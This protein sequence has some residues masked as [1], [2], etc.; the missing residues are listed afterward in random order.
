M[1]I[2]FNVKYRPQIES[3][4]YKVETRDG[5]PAKIIYW[6][7]KGYDDDIKLVVIIGE[8]GSQGVITMS[9]SGSFYSDY[10]VGEEHRYDLFIVTPEPKLTEFETAL[11]DLL[12]HC[13]GEGMSGKDMEKLARENSSRLLDLAKKE[14]CIGYTKYLQGH[15]DGV[16]SSE[17]EYQTGY[18]DGHSAAEKEIYTQLNKQ[19]DKIR[20][21]Q[22]LTL[23]D[24][25]INVQMPSPWI[26]ATNPPDNDRLVFICVNDNGVPQC[27]GCGYYRHRVW[28]DAEGKLDYPDYWMEIPELPKEE[29]K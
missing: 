27:V 26:P 17:K 8:D 5:E 23:N 9:K 10:L 1:K 12:Y 22:Q 24:I 7:L 11:K 20:N 25:G 3:G 2:D 15:I 21:L 19:M 18:F 13:V 16:A 14:L 6:D 4:E 29:K 28:V